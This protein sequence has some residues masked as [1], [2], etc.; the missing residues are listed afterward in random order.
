M[1]LA[2]Y[3]FLAASSLF[4]IVDPMAT[5]PAFITMNGTFASVAN[6]AIASAFGV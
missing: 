4:V 3:I 5:I 6:G 2:E 1:T